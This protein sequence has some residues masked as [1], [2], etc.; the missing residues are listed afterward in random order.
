MM[1]PMSSKERLLA[2]IEHRPVDRVPLCFEGVCH[3]SVVYLDRLFPDPFARARY[4]LDLGV[5]HALQLTPPFFASSDFE[6]RQREEHPA[7]EPVPLLV[8]EY[9]TPSGTLRQVV[10]RTG[11]YPHAQVPIFSD[12]HIPPGRTREY[13]VAQEADL[14]ALEVILRPPGKEELAVFRDQAREARRFCDQNGVLL[15]GGYPGVGDPLMWM[16]GVEPV[17]LAGLENPSFLEAYVAIVARWNLGIAELLIDAGV[18]VV[19]RRGWYESTDFWS[20][21]LYRRF[22]FDPLR[23]EVRSAHQAGVKLSYVMNSGAMPLLPLFRELGFDILANIDPQAPKMDLAEL[24]AQIGDCICLCGGVNN[25]H[26]LEEGS[27]EDVERAVQEALCALAPGSGFILAP[28][29]S[30]GFVDG[31]DQQIAERN[32]LAMIAAWKRFAWG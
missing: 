16:S 29:D 20:P 8:K 22:L 9:L 30:V 6:V 28:G 5:D 11:D 21:D 4:Y 12:H 32:V 23:Q 7:G 27:E 10:R 25:T 14:E 31:L 18:D 19:V 2:A 24:K 3:G 26:V 13:L 17:L 1:T 15:A